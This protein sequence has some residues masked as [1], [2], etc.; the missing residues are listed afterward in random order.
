M[1]DRSRVHNDC[2]VRVPEKETMQRKEWKND[3]S[4]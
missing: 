2:L 3:T 4:H 1:K